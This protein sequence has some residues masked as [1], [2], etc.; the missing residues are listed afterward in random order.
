MGLDGEMFYC[1]VG[2][3]FALFIDNCHLDVNLFC[4]HVSSVYKNQ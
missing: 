3:L 1:C 2:H 4:A